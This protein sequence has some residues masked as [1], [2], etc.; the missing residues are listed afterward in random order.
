MKRFFSFLCLFLLIVSPVWALS[1]SISSSAVTSHTDLS[2]SY[3]GMLFGTVGHT[4]HGISG[5]ML[6][7]LFYK[8]NEG[9]FCAAGVMI[10]YSSF[11]MVLRSTGEGQIASQ[12]SNSYYMIV[13]IVLGIV[14]VV[15]SSA[16]GYNLAQDLMMRV[17]VSGVKLADM[18]WSY[19]LRYLNSG[20]TLF[21]APRN[22]KQSNDSD[23]LDFV[24]A[25][26]YAPP[27]S[28]ATPSTAPSGVLSQVFSNEVCMYENNMTKMSLSSQSSDGGQSYN[29]GYSNGNLK[30]LLKGDSYT[31]GSSS[32]GSFNWAKL[33]KKV[34]EINVPK[35]CQAQS[36]VSNSADQQKTNVNICP[37]NF[38]AAQAIVSNLLPTA[39][40]YA[41]THMVNV[42]NKPSYCDDSKSLG[43]TEVEN[44]TSQ[45]M[46]SAMVAYMNAL[47]PIQ[48]ASIFN[49]NNN[50]H[51]FIGQAEQDGWASAGRYYWGLE[52]LTTQI[53][54][55]KKMSSFVNTGSVVDFSSKDN[56]S[57]LP[58][59]AEFFNYVVIGN[60][61]KNHQTKNLLSVTSL[62][63]NFLS[64]TQ[65]GGNHVGDPVSAIFSDIASQGIIA[66]IAKV[67]PILG[68]VL[69]FVK[70][71][72][73]MAAGPTTNDPILFLHLVGNIMINGA[74]NIF[75]SG[76]LFS[77]LTGTIDSIDCF[78]PLKGVSSAM[79]EWL[80]P[81]LFFAAFAFLAQGFIYCYYLPL[82]P[83]FIY[84]FAVLGW[85]AMVIEAML[86]APLVAL[87][88]T[89]PEGHDFLGR[90]EQALMLAVS[91]FIRPA[92]IVIGYFAAMLLSYVA[93]RY[94]IYTFSYVFGA[95]NY[96]LGL[97]LSG[98]L[99]SLFVVLPLFFSLFAL[100]VYQVITQSYALI[101]SLPDQVV[102]W[103]GISQQ[104]TY[105]NPDKMTGSIQSGFSGM[106]QQGKQL[107]TQAIQYHAN[108][109]AD[110]TSADVRLS[111]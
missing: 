1:P 93:L 97:G 64:T 77:I 30:P 63:S 74:G 42:V 104:S 45:A 38:Q 44:R 54:I 62:Y 8:F 99:I 86:A 85:L 33:T 66:W 69:V 61:D 2:M 103:V 13:R 52:K 102:K 53:N 20:G 36:A 35:T 92:L 68:P 18:T 71:A 50:T 94:V 108:K 19:G 96:Y 91:V 70:L 37:Y 32:C 87:G 57:V 84:S 90:A 24:N 11:L 34:G 31:F 56:P 60:A 76:I 65:K 105:F 67:I 16:T 59:T 110:T 107:A 27:S 3:L 98:F 40:D 48:A 46:F 73:V 28:S 17:V 15:P 109:P 25:A 111:R 55:A 82:Y 39:R 78:E 80:K 29:S 88:V 5:Q 14:L 26:V 106:G 10:T 9:L 6:G 100:V 12:K 75:V 81:V 58:P 43:D 4:I 79:T 72:A 22:V 101:F 7:K 89:H 41:C 23:F 83:Y 49:E 95:S 21:Y 47:H 51:A